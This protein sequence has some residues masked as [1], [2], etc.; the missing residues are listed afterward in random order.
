MMGLELYN[1]YHDQ[2]ETSNMMQAF[3]EK[4]KELYDLLKAWRENVGAELPVPNPVFNPDK[5][6]IWGKHPDRE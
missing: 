6:Y 3:P 5:R 2:S 1:L 4:A